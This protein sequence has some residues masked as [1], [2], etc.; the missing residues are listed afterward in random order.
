MISKNL[1]AYERIVRLVLAVIFLYAAYALFDQTALRILAGLFGLMMLVEAVA[2]HCGLLSRLGVKTT[3]DVLKNETRFLIG[4]LAIQFVIAYE[5]WQAGFE[6]IV[7]G[8]FVTTI[9]GALTKFGSS[10]PFP[11]FKDSVL[12]Y[13]SN[14]ATVFAYAVEWGELLVG[15]G[16]AV[17]VIGYVCAKSRSLHRLMLVL[18]VA[19][20]SGGVI[21]N[22]AFYFA[23]GWTSPGTHSV[24]LIMFWVQ[25][26]LMYVWL[27]QLITKNRS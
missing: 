17:A 8:T 26:V 10:N 25:A 14:N 27:S 19:A 22:L 16:L 7:G 5:W 24:N 15:L 23:A 18:M 1:N 2:G 12:T 3:T 11:W 4:L 9:G 20:L 21:M 6:K 13:A